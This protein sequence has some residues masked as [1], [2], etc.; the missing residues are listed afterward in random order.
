MMIPFRTDEYGKSFYYEDETGLHLLPY[1]PGDYHADGFRL[2]VSEEQLPDALKIS[3]SVSA[4][5]PVSVKRFGFRLGIDCYMDTYPQWNEKYFPTAL[6]CEK[7]AFWSCFQ[8]PLGKR[9]AVCAPEGIVSWKNEY[10]KTPEGDVGHR[11]YTSA[12]ELLNVYPQ[13]ERHP[14][15]PEKLGRQPLRAEL[16]YGCPEHEQAFENFVRKYAGLNIPAVNK[17]TLERGETLTLNG[18]PYTGALRPG[19][20]RIQ[21]ARQAELTVYVREDWFHYLDCARKSAEVCQQKPGTHV[22]SWYGFFSRVLYASVVKDAGYTEKLCRE[23][24]SLFAALTET[25]QGKYRMREETLP[26]RLQNTSGMLSLLADFYELTDNEKYLTRAND[27]A[28][29]L[30]EL[31]WEDGSYRTDRG[32]HYTCVIYPAKSMLELALAEQKAGFADRYQRHYDSAYRAIDNLAALLDDI[33]TEGEMTFEDGM[34]SCESLQL[35]YLATLLPEGAERQRFA[36]AAELVLKKH[37][38]LE[39]R[40]LPDCR[41]RGCTA[42]YWE[43]R[44]DLN[45]F[46]NMLNS[47]HGWT[48]WKTYATYYLYLLTGKLPYLTDTMDTLGAC[49]QCVDD[50]GI[51]HWGYIADPC[52][53]G[54]NLKQGCRRGQV[55]FEKTVVGEA[56]LPMISDWYRQNEDDLILQ[57]LLSCTEDEDWDRNYGGSCDNDVHEHFKCMM[58]TVFGKAFIH[59]TDHGFVCYQCRE[60]E[61]GFTGTDPHLCW[62]IVHLEAD[63][64][65]TLNGKACRLHSGFNWIDAE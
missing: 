8:S 48:S 24:D 43:A 17:F 14:A 19:L 1:H 47:P 65:L 29:W 4:E 12:V 18:K 33:Q 32:T 35:G 57:Y 16:Y 42:R 64:V 28:D 2:S 46:A 51:L 37:Q 22:E 10:N 52:V 50:Q 40:I 45:F 39:Q 11:I 55:A 54:L 31:Q 20:N 15:S 63:R 36:E 58:E 5:E 3:I 44:Y 60:T 13:P 30:M 62:W 34:I 25:V 23:F 7:Q 6:R 59:E 38:C 56:Y 27:L 53:V 61:A 26:Y 41:T 9:I 21:A 49:M